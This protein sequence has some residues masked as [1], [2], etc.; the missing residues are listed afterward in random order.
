MKKIVLTAMLSAFAFAGFAQY[1]DNA[2]GTYE[3]VTERGPYMTNRFFD[4]WFIGVGGGVNYYDGKGYTK[5]DFTDRLAPALDVSLGKWIT[6][7][8]GIRAQYAG[9]STKSFTNVGV[10]ATGNPPYE[11]KFD[12]MSFHGDFLWNISNAIGGYKETRTWDGIPFAWFC[13]A[14]A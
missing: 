9:L 10:Q 8:V 6:P 4:N 11:R 1:A 2:P 7:S 14:P 5:G 12:V 13:V 3:R